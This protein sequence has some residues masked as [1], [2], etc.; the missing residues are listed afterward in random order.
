MKKKIFMIIIVMVLMVTLIPSV[1]AINI[2][3]CD[4]IIP[5]VNIDVKIA[6]TVHTI[7]TVIKIAVPVILVISKGR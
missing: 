1:N 2:R 7:I 5:G 6:N 4:S 3:G